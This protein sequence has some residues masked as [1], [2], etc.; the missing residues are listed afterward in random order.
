V[1]RGS[2]RDLLAEGR[3]PSP[4]VSPHSQIGQVCRQDEPV[5]AGFSGEIREAIAGRSSNIPDDTDAFRLINA[6]PTACGLI[7]TVTTDSVL[8]SLTTGCEYWKETIATF[9]G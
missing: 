7:A 4:R 8:Q 6:N 2:D 5:D 9:G 1:I 3:L